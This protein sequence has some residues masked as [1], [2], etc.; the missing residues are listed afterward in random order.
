MSGSSG[1]I[2]TGGDFDKVAEFRDGDTRPV[3]AKALYTQPSPTVRFFTGLSG[4]LAY[5]GEGAIDFQAVAFAEHT[6]QV[7]VDLGYGWDKIIER[8]TEGIVT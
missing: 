1:C 2:D 6:D 3:T 4:A 5:G 7:L 8:K